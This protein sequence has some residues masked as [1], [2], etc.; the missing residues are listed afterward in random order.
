MLSRKIGPHAHCGVEQ[1]GA[2]WE[3]K[4]EKKEDNVIEKFSTPG[5]EKYRIIIFYLKLSINVPYLY[6]GPRRTLAGARPQ[7]ALHMRAGRM[8]V[9][10]EGH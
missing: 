8:H 10:T 5:S 7:R 4:N 3:K 9:A 6:G 2:R 1:G